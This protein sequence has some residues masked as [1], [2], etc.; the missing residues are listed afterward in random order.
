TANNVLPSQVLNE[1]MPKLR[2]LEA[3][4]PPGYRLE[5]G[6]EYEEQAKGFKNL[7]V[8]MLISVTMIFLALVIQ[9]RHAVKPLIVFAAIPFGVMGALMSLWVMG[10]PFGFMAF[11]GVASLI[12]VIVSH[13]IVLFDF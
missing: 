7:A 1:A 10:T 4:M 5:I 3:R 2:A 9:F 13:I 8:V 6:G 12:G 11:L